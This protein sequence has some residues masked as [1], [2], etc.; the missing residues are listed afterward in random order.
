MTKS[1]RVICDS[2]LSDDVQSIRETRK[3]CM[4]VAV[5]SEDYR[6]PFYLLLL[7]LISLHLS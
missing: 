5:N 2:A 3:M 6:M 4:L 7:P 1:E